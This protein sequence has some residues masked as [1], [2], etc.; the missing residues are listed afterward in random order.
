MPYKCVDRN[1]MMDF[2]FDP[3]PM[4]L[5][6]AIMAIMFQTIMCLC[7]NGEGA[8][9]GEGEG[10]A[11]GGAEGGDDQPPPPADEGEEAPEEEAAPEE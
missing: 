8:E 6:V 11:Q 1:P 7:K 2:V 10:G 5:F 3:V 9:G 4:W